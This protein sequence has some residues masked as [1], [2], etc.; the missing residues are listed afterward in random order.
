MK[1]DYQYLHFVKIQE[2]PKTSVWSCQT[3]SGDE[4][5]K[6]EW[7]GPW[8]QYCYFPTQQAV[9]SSGCMDDIS[10]FLKHLNGKGCS[11]G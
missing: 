8:R 11:N 2:K 3:R 9:Y 10:D 1:T 5:G 4:L 6:V 7:Y